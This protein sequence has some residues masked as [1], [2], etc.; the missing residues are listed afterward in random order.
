[1]LLFEI[2]CDDIAVFT[3]FDEI[4]STRKSNCSILRFIII[5]IKIS[6]ANLILMGEIFFWFENTIQRRISPQISFHN[7][8]DRYS[9]K[10]LKNRVTFSLPIDRLSQITR[11]ASECDFILMGSG[12]SFLNAI[13]L[14]SCDRGFHSSSSVFC[15]VAIAER[16][17]HATRR[18][19]PTRERAAE[20]SLTLEL[21]SM[22][23]K[24][25]IVWP[26]RRDAK[27]VE[28]ASLLRVTREFNLAVSTA[29]R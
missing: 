27:E 28:T 21:E 13:K 14:D 17:V 24:G 9:K 20:R 5:S 7:L 10:K 12:A 25:R 22:S 15:S 11:S 6:S 23:A 26:G 19:L 29:K 8:F 4:S 16:V 18:V 3:Q 1:M 2:L